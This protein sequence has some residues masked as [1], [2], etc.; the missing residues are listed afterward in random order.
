MALHRDKNGFLLE[1]GVEELPP[2][3][4]RPAIEALGSAVINGLK[5][6]FPAVG[7]LT[8]YSTP[9]RLALTVASL[10]IRQEDRT[11]VKIGPAVKIAYNDQGELTKAGIGFANSLGV[12]FDQLKI[13]RTVKGEHISAEI[14]VKG[15]ESKE[16]LS[17]LIQSA[18]MN[19]S[20]PRSM[21]WNDRKTRFAR[22]IRWVTALLGDEVIDLEL[23]GLKASAFS[24]GKVVE[25]KAELI[26]IPDIDIYPFLL[27]QHF[28]IVNRE[29]RKR[30]ILQQVEEITEVIK[31]KVEWGD[32]LLD[33]IT[34]IVEFP[35]V[36][37][38]EFSA[39]YLKLPPKIIIS[40]L[41][42]NQKYATLTDL[43]GKLLNR[44]VFV[45]DNLPQYADSTRAGNEKVV[46][47]RLDDAVFY[48]N[49]DC[50]KSIAY[51]VGK[52]NDIMFQEKLGTVKEKT[53]RLVKIARFIGSVLKLDPDKQKVA[54]RAAEL[55][56]FDLA[57]AMVAEKEFTSLQGYMGANYARFWGES[58]SV[59]LAIQEH[60]QPTYMNDDV[61]SSLGG[62]IV[63]IADRVDTICAFF[64]IG[65]IPTGSNDPYALK[66][67]ANGIVR[68]I[69]E[70]DLQIN[71]LD[72]ITF[73]S[74]L[75]SEKFTSQGNDKLV[76]TVKDFFKQ[77]ADWVFQQKGIDYDVR[78]TVLCSDVL[79]PADSW[80]SA[81]AVMK[82]RNREDFRALV[83]S[84]K[85]VSNII[86]KEKQFGVF[87]QML[88]E[89]EAEKELFRHT[90]LIQD[91]VNELSTK[92]NYEAMIELFIGLKVFIDRFFDEVLVNVD[93]KEI[94]QNRYNLLNTIRS[95][96]LKAGDLSL[97]VIQGEK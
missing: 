53:E 41:A 63:S 73:S 88:A 34:D 4:I 13:I 52:L 83:L 91:E 28:V 21:R 14:T 89:T 17:A 72:L 25:Q 82:I 78:N 29:E 71:L 39:D 96:F 68:M 44:F 18:V 49:E 51:F 24:Q 57:T 97:I 67:S 92:Q 84:F 26:E 47:A 75:L 5:E 76:D 66:R 20:F 58:E 77:R 95:I 8:I 79:Y 6:S 62:L 86:A 22:P 40:T 3:Y 33:E 19:L 7:D 65:Y 64:G 54:D 10:P 81:I 37:M 11:E 9:R 55:C 60:Y 56:K 38:A 23:V 32:N 15:R 31:A 69:I 30:M 93:Q 70:K 45:A 36:V 48:Y 46:K 43:N 94:K 50:S 27:K 16:I 59:A 2:G 12:G 80:K 74:S 87:D 1:I 85:R 90:I 61:P 35:T 42:K